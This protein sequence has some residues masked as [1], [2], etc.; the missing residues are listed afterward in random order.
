MLPAG[1]TLKPYYLQSKF[2]NKSIKSIRDA[3]LI[4]LLL[5]IIVVILF[6]RSLQSS[7]TILFIIPVT[8]AF[9]LLIMFALKYTLN[10]M[11]IGAI[12]AALGLIIDDAVIVI[13]QIHRHREEQPDVPVHKNIRRSIGFLLPSMIGSSLS[14]IVIFIPF[15]LMSGVAGA[16]FKIMAYTMIITL[17]CSF[18]VTAII[19][20]VFYG[21]VAGIIPAKFKN[22]KHQ[23][24]KTWVDFFLRH[25]WLSVAFLCILAAITIFALPRLQTGFLPEMD[26]GS[27]VLDYNSPPGTSIEE[28]NRILTQADSIVMNTQEVDSYSRRTGTQLGFFITEPNRG[29]YLIRLKE[30]R[31]RST[32]KVIADIRKR[33]EHRLPVLQVDFGQV[34]GDMLGDLMSSAQPIEIKV[35]GR[36]RDKLKDYAKN[37]TSLVKQVPGTADVFNGIVIAGPNINIHPDYASLARFGLTAKELQYQVKTAIEGQ[38]VDSVIDQH[39]LTT[40]R[41]IY[42]GGPKRTVNELQ[43]MQILLPSGLPVLLSSLATITA[44]SG[45]AEQERENLQA[46]IAV[47]ARL[48]GRDLGSVMQDIKNAI[49]KNINFEKG[50]GVRY[51]GDYAQQQQSFNDLLMILVLASLLVLFVLMVLFRKPLV[52]IIILLMGISGIAGSVLALYLTGTPL[53]VGSYMGI[54]MIVGIIAENAIFTF[55]QFETA[56]QDHD[57]KGAL[58]YAIAARLRPKLMTAIGAI[59]A[60]MP[61][62]LGIRNGSTDAPAFGDCGNWRFY[63]CAAIAFNCFPEFASPV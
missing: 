44:G 20:P 58:N 35:F 7:I 13:E 36:D 42:P 48:E 19:L 30:N 10:I 9:S 61:L 4:G 14:T 45:V 33:I 54:I 62:A 56:L 11:T 17:T 28:T 12:A 40:V 57:Q 52:S 6:L 25:T 59:L 63:S 16:Y 46:I 60:L 37:I 39:Q 38:P 47:T 53:N 24:K 43:K 31:N 2:V 18:F 21:F 49:N 8:L 29:D 32:Q 23:Q 27:I 34:I 55:Q 5:A 1:V 22:V 50:Y 41:L 3:L 15:S 26:E 51:G